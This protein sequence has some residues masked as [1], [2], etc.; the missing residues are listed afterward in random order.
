ML[1]VVVFQSPPTPRRSLVDQ[2]LDERSHD[3][4]TAVD[5]QQNGA[6]LPVEEE[7]VMVIKVPTSS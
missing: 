4:E 3:D 5:R 6:D 2:E 7:E 1:C